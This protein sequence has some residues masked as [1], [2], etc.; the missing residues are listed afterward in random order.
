MD[1]RTN[2][3]GERKPFQVDEQMSTPLTDL[4][5]EDANKFFRQK[6]NEIRWEI[7]DR[8]GMKNK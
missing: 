5:K 4:Y 2:T 1:H 6:E 3:E 8:E 7:R